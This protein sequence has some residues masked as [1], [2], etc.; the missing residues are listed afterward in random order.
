MKTKNIIKTITKSHADYQSPKDCSL[1][2][3]AKSYNLK[4]GASYL[5]VTEVELDCYTR[6]GWVKYK[7]LANREHVY[8]KYQ[9]DI[10][11]TKILLPLEEIL[12]L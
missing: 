5:G 8:N 6:L 12:G 11:M 7:T 2:G 3:V 10:L 4:D 9:L 1:D